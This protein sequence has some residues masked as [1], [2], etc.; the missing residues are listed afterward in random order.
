M[1]LFEFVMVLVSIVIGLAIGEFLAGALRILRADKLP[2]L[3]W[4]HLSWAVWIL[5]QLIDHWLYRWEYTTIDVGAWGVW[6]IAFF[7]IP[8][9]LLFLIAGLVFPGNDNV[10][11]VRSFYFQRRRVLFGSLIILNVLY[12]IESWTLAGYDFGFRG[13]ILRGMSVLL[14]IALIVSKRPAVHAAGA[15][16]TWVLLFIGVSSLF[17]GSRDQI[18]L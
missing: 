9:L 3:Y 6:H 11:E 5:F 14:L 13:D 15:I 8:T 12:S 18:G 16:V 2:R 10:G 4:V 17:G 7:L 1:S